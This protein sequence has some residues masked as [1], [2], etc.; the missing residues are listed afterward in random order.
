LG[1]ETPATTPSFCRRAMRV[2]CVVTRGVTRWLKSTLAQPRITSVRGER[3]RLA[4]DFA[5]GCKR[6]KSTVA[7]A[8]RGLI[9]RVLSTW[10][11]VNEQRRVSALVEDSTLRAAQLAVCSTARTR[12]CG[13]LVPQTPQE[14]A[15]ASA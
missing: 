15:T 11:A 6:C 3:G 1:V 12:V 9:V 14:C 10:I 4:N 5:G 13:L 2:R 7:L 8:R